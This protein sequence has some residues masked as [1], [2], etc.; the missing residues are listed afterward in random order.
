L[1]VVGAVVTVMEGVVVDAEG[2]EVV[3]EGVVEE[4]TVTATVVEAVVGTIDGDLAMDDA[5][6]KF[7]WLCNRL[8]IRMMQPRSFIR[9]TYVNITGRT[10]LVTLPYALASSW[11][12]CCILE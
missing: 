8:A 2:D 5:S 9:S 11:Y 6:S 7:L 3:E 4:V 12:Y 10:Q 1:V